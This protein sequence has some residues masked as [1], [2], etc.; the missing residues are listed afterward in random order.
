L[1]EVDPFDGGPH[2]GTDLADVS[3]V[4]NGQWATYDKAEHGSFAKRSFVA[5]KRD[6][7]FRAVMSGMDVANGKLLVPPATAKALEAEHGE[8]FYFSAIS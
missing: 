1:N 4:K 3:I 5:I 6:G 7:E 8:K 2:Y